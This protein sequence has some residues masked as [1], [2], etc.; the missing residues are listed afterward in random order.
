MGK[1]SS[2]KLRAAECTCVKLCRPAYGSIF[3]I[4]CILNLSL[5]LSF[6]LFFNKEPSKGLRHFVKVRAAYRNLHR[7]ESI[8]VI[9]GNLRD[10]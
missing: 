2:G 7:R 8:T 5:S 10:F 1:R 6:I 3:G 9:C 4:K